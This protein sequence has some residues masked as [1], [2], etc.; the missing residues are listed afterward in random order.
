MRHKIFIHGLEAK[1]VSDRNKTLKNSSLKPILSVENEVKN[2]QSDDKVHQVRDKDE[3]DNLEEED[4]DIFDLDEQEYSYDSD[5]SFH[6]EEK[7]SLRLENSNH[8]NLSPSIKTK[9]KIMNEK[10][11]IDVLRMKREIE[12]NKI[13][14][15]R[16]LNEVLHSNYR[17]TGIGMNGGHISRAIGSNTAHRQQKIKDYEVY[18]N[19]YKGIHKKLEIEKHLDLSNRKWD[20]EFYIA[21]S[22]EITNKSP[23]SISIFRPIKPLHIQTV[24]AEISRYRPVTAPNT[25]TKSDMST[26]S[27]MKKPLINTRSVNS[28]PIAKTDVNSLEN[29]RYFNTLSNKSNEQQCWEYW[30]SEL[31]LIGSTILHND[32]S[33][34]HS[35]REPSKG[36]VSVI[37]YIGLLF[38]LEDISW[39]ITRQLI[40]REISA[41]QKFMS[42][43]DPQKIP[44]KR[45]YRANTLLHTEIMTNIDFYASPIALSCAIPMI[46]RYVET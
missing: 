1:I 45:L 18:V 11:C 37:G 38:G 4:R 6:L 14:T 15:N 7:L 3:N 9:I 5:L 8:K 33:E 12:K 10:L 20:K 42:E 35:L 41:L 28:S 19:I 31:H 34:L 40:L 43:I 2:E 44:I 22:L 30:I 29:M 26:F 21:N 25:A 17:S 36:I 13:S 16:T 24:E 32:L 23:F 46:L 27:P 39:N